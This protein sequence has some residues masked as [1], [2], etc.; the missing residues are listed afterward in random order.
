MYQTISVN[1]HNKTSCIS[2]TRNETTQII[3][4]GILQLPPELRLQIFAYLFRYGR[5]ETVG[6]NVQLTPALCRANRIF[7][8]ESL[9][10][11]AKTSA[12]II[13][14]D[15]SLHTVNDR[16]N[17]WLDA[18]GDEALSYVENLQLSRHWHLQVPT[19]FQGNIGFY[20]KL[21]LVDEAWKCVAGTYPIANDKRG[22]RSESVELLRT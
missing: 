4:M 13:Q 6:P 11:Y 18:L 14:T 5:Q 10:L 17:M 3:E 21:Q 7:R 9:P 1:E 19:R 20:V 12:F 22:M 16:V 8:R 15:D 2:Y